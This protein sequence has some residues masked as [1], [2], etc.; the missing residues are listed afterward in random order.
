MRSLLAER[1]PAS[2][3]I[4]VGPGPVAARTLSGASKIVLLFPDAIGLGYSTIER[5]LARYAPLGSVE[6]L[7]GRKRHFTFDGRS[8]WA[9]HYRRFLEWTMLIECCVGVSILVATPFLL[10]VDFVRGQK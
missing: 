7:N 1:Y 9:L 6:V 2:T 10:L 4:D 3:F 8:R 5:D